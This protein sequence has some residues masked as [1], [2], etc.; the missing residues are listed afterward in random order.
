MLNVKRNPSRKNIEQII[1]MYES[2]RTTAEKNTHTLKKYSGGKDM[3]MFKC[4]K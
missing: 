4:A 2:G 1:T 3:Q